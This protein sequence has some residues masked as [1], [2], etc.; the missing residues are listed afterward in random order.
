MGA[1]TVSETPWSPCPAYLMTGIKEANDR[2]WKAEAERTGR[3]VEELQDE[4]RRRN[5]AYF[6]EWKSLQRPG[7]LDRLRNVVRKVVRS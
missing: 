7:F 3:T 2:F 4:R 1:T 5:E 6:A